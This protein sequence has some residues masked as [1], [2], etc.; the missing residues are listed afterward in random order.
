MT[1]VRFARS[2]ARAEA[3]VW[4]ARYFLNI[5]SMKKMA[6]FCASA[7]A[8]ALHWVAI[9]V[10]LSFAEVSRVPE[11]IAPFL[12]LTSVSQA[13]VLHTGSAGFLMADGSDGD[14]ERSLQ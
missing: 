6:F 1:L 3:F 2:T 10:T 14:S 11:K 5:Q 4:R 7:L 9:A 13:G 12:L 8:P